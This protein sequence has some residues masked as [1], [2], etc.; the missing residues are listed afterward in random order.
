[1][2]HQIGEK[3]KSYILIVA[4]LVSSPAF[5]EQTSPFIIHKPQAV[6]DCEKN[7]ALPMSP[8]GQECHRKL[9]QNY[10]ENIQREIARRASQ[11]NNSAPAPA[12]Q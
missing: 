2:T 10:V 12:Q 6:I 5:S 8:E 7:H 4:L 3:M 11:K 9:R 1:M